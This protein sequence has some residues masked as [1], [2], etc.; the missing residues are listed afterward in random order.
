MRNLIKATVMMLLVC[1]LAACAS[2]SQK[3]PCDYHG[4]F[5]GTQTKI[6]QW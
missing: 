2:N 1:F 3:A 4:H 5:C 6:N